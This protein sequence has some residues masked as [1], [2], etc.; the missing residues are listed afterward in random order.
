MIPELKETDIRPV[1]KMRE[2]DHAILGAGGRVRIKGEVSLKIGS[3]SS[4][5]KPDPSLLKQR[6]MKRH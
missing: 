2:P 3:C 4:P 6:P 1:K 5:L